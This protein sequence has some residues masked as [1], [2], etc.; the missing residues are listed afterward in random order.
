MSSL[1][2]S[3]IKGNRGLRLHFPPFCGF[4]F[5]LAVVEWQK[6]P[7]AFSH[8]SKRE[9]GALTSAA[10]EHSGYSPCATHGVKP[11][12]NITDSNGVKIPQNEEKFPF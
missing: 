7:K 1:L 5:V 10:A 11:I 9:S 4:L 12:S 2:I 6:G 3:G 8:F